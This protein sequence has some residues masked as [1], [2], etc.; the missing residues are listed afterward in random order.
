MAPAFIK[1]VKQATD[2]DCGI[3]CLAMLFHL[4]LAEVHA[5]AAKALKVWPDAE[6]LTNRKL[7]T[8]ARKLGHPL[9]AMDPKDTAAGDTGI[10]M[11][12]GNKKYHF[13]VVFKGVIVEPTY[14]DI[15][16]LDA[17]L[18]MYKV[19]PHRFLQP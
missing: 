8:I 1:L 9:K 16:E 19:R 5:V 14:G 11:V 17:Y 7:Q 4:P 2:Y 13:V 12:G 6:G 18:K 10:L 3:A 15:W